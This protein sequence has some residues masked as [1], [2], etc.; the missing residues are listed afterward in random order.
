MRSIA[1]CLRKPSSGRPLSVP[2]LCDFALQVADAMAY[3]ENRRLV[4]RNLAARNVLM[5]AKDKVCQ[6]YRLI[7]CCY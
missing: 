5:F 2:L 6:L 4:H 1:D 3:L 7:V